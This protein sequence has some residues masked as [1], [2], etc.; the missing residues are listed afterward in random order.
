LEN[1]GSCSDQLELV[2]SCGEYVTLHRHST[3]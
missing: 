2:Y 1:G 3:S